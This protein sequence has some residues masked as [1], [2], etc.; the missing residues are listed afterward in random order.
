[1][2]SGLGSFIEEMN[3]EFTLP[4]EIQTFRSLHGSG[5]KGRSSFRTIGDKKVVCHAGKV[6]PFEGYSMK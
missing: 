2:G 5:H 1:L 4:P 3:V 6:S